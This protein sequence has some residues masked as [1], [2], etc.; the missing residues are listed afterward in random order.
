MRLYNDLLG[1][2][3]SALMNDHR[4]RDAIIEVDNNNGIVT[5]SGVVKSADIV[6]AAEEVASQP[7]G[8][9]KVVNLLRVRD[10]A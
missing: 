3:E 2:V 8:V 5:L 4:T 1:E 6:S 7:S 9:V 10:G